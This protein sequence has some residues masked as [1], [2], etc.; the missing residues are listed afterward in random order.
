MEIIDVT[1]RDGGHAVNF[2]WPVHVAREYYKLISN[3]DSVTYVE[4]GYWKQTSK[5][6][7]RFYNLDIAKLVE[8]IGDKPKKKV[9]VMIDY[10]YCKKDLNEYPDCKQSVVGMIRVCSRKNDIDKALPFIQKLKN[11]TG[12]KVSLNVFNISNYSKK[13]IDDVAEKVKNYNLDYVYFA[14]T[15]GSLDFEVDSQRFKD[16]VSVLRESN[17]KVGMHLHDH[18]GKAYSNFKHLKSIGFTGFDAST[19]G[20]GK[21]VGN[22]RLENVIEDKELID[23]M[24]FVARNEKKFTMR[25]SPYGVI[26]AKYGITDY[27]AYYAE[28]NKITI[29]LF[30]RICKN[31]EDIDKDVFNIEKIK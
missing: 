8:V 9:A 4:M 19:R 20:M 23:L 26:T 25:V 15:H 22:L 31:I 1:L 7:N 18:R 17:I 11:K 27:Y 30:D 12:L 21:G 3:I 16:A 14:D 6:S 2:D 28:K 29:E 5:T 13:E 10:H 24:S